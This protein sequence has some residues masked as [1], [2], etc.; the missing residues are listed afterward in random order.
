MPTLTYIEKLRDPRWQKVRLKVFER[1][2]WKCQNDRCQSP[3]HTPLAVHH[4]GYLP[5]HE[6]WDYPLSNFITLCEWC[7]DQQHAIATAEPL[8]EGN[9]YEWGKLSELLHFQP[10]KYLTEQE[11]CIVCA[12]I[13]ADY[14]PDA[15]G[16]LLPGDDAEIVARSEKFAGQTN[17]IPVFLKSIEAGWKYCGRWRVQA[18]TVNA[19]E[20]AIQQRCSNLGGIPISMVLFLEKESGAVPGHTTGKSL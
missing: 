6:P 3:E 11:G 8:V 1:D 18:A 12:C 9:N 10:E 19:A 2:G 20:I 17:F 4:K 15:P 7:H 5:G 14:N 16:I 13:R